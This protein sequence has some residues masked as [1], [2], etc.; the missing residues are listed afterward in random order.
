[1]SSHKQSIIMHKSSH[2]DKSISYVM[3]Y[4]ISKYSPSLQSCN[5][6]VLLYVSFYINKVNI[7]YIELKLFSLA[8]YIMNWFIIAVDM[9]WRDLEC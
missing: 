9:N 2:F 4:V 5:L 6:A 1:M 3:D 7:W 8:Y